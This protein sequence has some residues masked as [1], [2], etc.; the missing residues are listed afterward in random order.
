MAIYTTLLKTYCESLTEHK[1]SKPRDIIHYS[2]PLL[3]DFPYPF[4]AE[5][6]RAEFQE[7]FIRHFFMRELGA[8]TPALFKLYLEDELVPVMEKYNP[9]LK[10]LETD[11]DWLTTE[12]W[13]QHKANDD[14]R[15]AVE[16]KNATED[17]AR[18]Y[19]RGEQTTDNFVSDD[20]YA[21]DMTVNSTSTTNSTTDT[22]ADTSAHEETTGTTH[23]TTVTD[24]TTSQ[25]DTP[26]GNLDA[27]LAGKYLSGAE[28]TDSTV[29]SDG[30]TAGTLES[31]AHSDGNTTG[32]STTTANATT[33]IDDTDH[34]EEDRYVNTT[35]DDT[36][37]HDNK[38]HDDLS[39]Y[40]T[41]DLD[42]WIE[43]KGYHGMTPAEI[44]SQYLE[45]IQSI[46]KLIFQELEIL[47]MEVF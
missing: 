41:A 4:Y 16:E 9:M 8:E 24:S 20:Q 10:L 34:K 36:E 11:I 40:D 44:I 6:K 37:S 5:S 14:E 19:H 45:R 43:H 22:T 39:R 7:R 31:T 35:Q 28:H 29:T 30:T 38:Y 32:K 46:Y 17:K 15:H 47:F 26:Q 13:K 23:D 18:K 42:E 27:F 2:A 21:R 12:R 3:F 33:D 25:T 1:Y